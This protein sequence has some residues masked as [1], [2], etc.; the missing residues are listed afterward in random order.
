MLKITKMICLKTGVKTA[1]NT[2]ECQYYF[3]N[4]DNVEGKEVSLTEKEIAN[5]K[6]IT[7]QFI[8]SQKKLKE[9]YEVN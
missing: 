8:N 4:F 7:K 1:A 9:L 3:F 6:R 5:H 2:D